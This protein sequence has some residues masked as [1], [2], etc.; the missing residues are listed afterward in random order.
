MVKKLLMKKLIKARTTILQEYPF[1]G[2]L[3]MHLRFAFGDCKTAGTDMK[4]II[5]DPEW[6]QELSDEEVQFVL[7]HEVLHNALQ[8]CLR[9]RSGGYHAKLYNIAADIV[10]NSN[11]LETLDADEFVIDGEPVMHRAPDGREGS[12]YSAEQVYD[13]LADKYG[14]DDMDET[15]VE[16]SLVDDHNFWEYM[17]EEEQELLKAGWANH[18]EQALKEGSTKYGAPHSIRELLEINLDYRSKLNWRKI[19]EDFLKLCAS[20]YD[21]TFNPPDRRFAGSDVILPSFYDIEEEVPDKLWFLIDTSGSID[22]ETLTEVYH[23]IQAA[24]GQFSR[25]S[26]MVSCFDTE[27]TEPVE[28]DET[29]GLKEVSLIGGGGTSFECIFEYMKE[30]MKDEL[31]E[32]IIILTDG[33]ADY[34]AKDAAMGVPV[35]WIIVGSEKEVPWGKVVRLE[36]KW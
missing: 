24:I 30:H 10:V 3:L 16:A 7:L 28:F 23:E 29:T 18:V 9:M 5:F 17:K 36:A 31:P 15:E 19:L 6:L 14:S 33:F 21:Y 20:G 4:R 25:F 1:Y 11:I 27:V 12:C 35:L 26:G 13:M 32:A 2:S 34:P 8:H 22:K